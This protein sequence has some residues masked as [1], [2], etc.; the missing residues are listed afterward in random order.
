MAGLMQL[1]ASAKALGIPAKE[2]RSAETQA[3]LQE[4]ISAALS[5]GNSSTATKPRKKSTTEAPRKRGRPKGS[6][7]KPKATSTTAKRGPGRPRKASS[8]GDNGGRHLIGKINWSK[9]GNWNPREG[10]I[11][12]VIVEALR[13]F[14]GDRDKAFNLL[15]KDLKTLVPPKTRNNRKRDMEERKDY[16]RYLIAR[17]A[18]AFALATGQHEK[19][20]NRAAYGTAG[21][22]TGSFRRKGTRGRPKAQAARKSTRATATAQKASQ[23]VKRG[24]G[25]P[26]GSKNKPKTRARKSTAR[27]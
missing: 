14:K 18:W 4:L 3:E 6:T 11:P 19:S 25:R 8:N 7:N 22:G 9:T 27:R 21:T 16:L 2:I 17:N 20:E 13:K 10:S 5:G 23:G 1:R 26:K 12:A 15:V 24:P